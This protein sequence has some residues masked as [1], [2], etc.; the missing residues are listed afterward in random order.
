MVIA[1]RSISA[2]EKTRIEAAVAE[3]E[4]RTSAE[5][6]LVVAKLSDSYAPY[7]LLWAGVL[8]LVAGGIGAFLVPAL[9]VRI[10]FAGEASL[11]VLGGLAFHWLPLR[12]MLVPAAVKTHHARQLARLE[13]AALVHDRTVAETGLL[14]F[15]ALGERH[16]EILVDRG[17]ARRIPETAWTAVIDNF[18]RTVKAG[19]I[20][21]GLIAAIRDCTSVLA[22]QFPP[23]AGGPK[24]NEIANQVVEL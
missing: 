9:D 20:A 2:D 18:L 24:A 17:I 7:P 16:V 13:F 14:L 5:F 23:A 6:A 22:Q 3:A 1:M 19:R 12:L 4:T 15:I 11:F 8:A 10:L 21:D